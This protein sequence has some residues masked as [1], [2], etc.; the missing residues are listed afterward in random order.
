[1]KPPHDSC[2]VLI[3]S[4]RCW[5][6]GRSETSVWVKIS[7]SSTRLAHGNQTAGAK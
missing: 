4:T 5:R 1:M 6:T 3:H 7:H 2:F